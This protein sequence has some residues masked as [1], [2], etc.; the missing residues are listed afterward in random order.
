MSK[1][2]NNE[3][4]WIDFRIEN[5]ETTNEHHDLDI[6]PNDE[7]ND[8]DNDFP[9]ND[10]DYTIS[11]TSSSSQSQTLHTPSTISSRVSSQNTPI[12]SIRSTYQ[13]D[14]GST[15]TTASHSRYDHSPPIY[16]ELCVE[17]F[18]T[19]QFNE[20]SRD[21]T[22][23]KA[24]TFR[25]GG[26]Y[27]HCS[28]KEFG[29]RMGLYP[30]A[31]ADNNNF[32]RFLKSGEVAP[33]KDFNY[34]RFWSRIAQG[35]YDIR[36]L[37]EMHISSP[38][39]RI[40]HKMISY[41]ITSRSDTSSVTKMDLWYLSNI[42]N[43]DK[44]CNVAHCL[45]SY[46]TEAAW[47][48]RTSPIYGGHFVTRLAK[49]YPFFTNAFRI[50][51]T[52][53]QPMTL[54]DQTS[55]IYMKVLHKDVRSRVLTLC[56][57]WDS[58]D[59]ENEGLDENEDE[60]EDALPTQER[61]PAMAEISVHV[62]NVERDI[63][64]MKGTM[65]WLQHSMIRVF[66]HLQMPP[67]PPDDQAGPS[68]TQQLESSLSDVDYSEFK[69]RIWVTTWVVVS[70]ISV[71]VVLVFETEVTMNLAMTASSLDMFQLGR[72]RRQRGNGSSSFFGNVIFDHESLSDERRCFGDKL[73]C[74]LGDGCFG[75]KGVICGLIFSDGGFGV[76][77]GSGKEFGHDDFQFGYVVGQGGH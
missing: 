26:S 64:N 3:P 24:L 76:G 57:P 16:R 9:N 67:E 27:H 55:L 39:H 5:L 45:A 42:L 2:T 46:L 19:Y 8:E 60:E 33:A 13:S 77:N 48:T 23:D 25:L 31:L 69:L 15:S 65:N 68:T 30:Q 21:Y 7:P 28:V 54:I 53:E 66:N 11:T 70:A 20:K 72:P 40:L 73:S 59:P 71:L 51:L 47:N 12:N 63:D 14:S 50:E 29:V 38:I 35:R 75:V 58:G 36:H 52:P 62:T 44:H 17:F 41:S 49:S 18:S 74:G 1:H 32:L 37:R 4:E 34:A 22:D 61:D 56:N 10:D 6:Q 43:K